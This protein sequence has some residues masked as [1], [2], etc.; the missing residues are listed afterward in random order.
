[1]QERHRQESHSSSV[2][3]R[4]SSG[5]RHQSGSRSKDETD[6]K[7]GCQM[8]MEN[9]TPPGSK[10]T[11]QRPTLNWSQDI[12]EPHKQV[13]KPAARDAPEMPQHTVKSVVKMPG[14]PS[15]EPAAGAKVKP[16]IKPAL[17]LA[18][19]GVGRGQVIT[20]KLQ[21]IANMGP[22]A[23]SQYTGNEKDRK[24]KPE[25]KKTGFPTPEEK[26]ACRHHEKHKDWVINHKEESIG[27]R[28]L[29]IKR[30]SHQYDQEIR[31]LRF[32]QPD[33]HVDLTCHR[34]LGR[35]VQWIK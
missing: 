2:G 20:E 34:R 10:A 13:W 3:S 35:R 22:A 27:E 25:S 9:W 8:P 12:L 17:E 1:M 30:Q 31:A 18:S 16:W 26:E 24:K 15:P 19:C 28:Y 6:T 4:S 7:K 14:K 29:S 33:D 5:K 23:A 11:S 32:F 21:Q